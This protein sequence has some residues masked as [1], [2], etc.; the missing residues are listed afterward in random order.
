M[1]IP[2]LIFS[3][4]LD[5]ARVRDHH[6]L[7]LFLYIFY[8]GTNPIDKVTQYAD[9]MFDLLKRCI[10]LAEVWVHKESYFPLKASRRR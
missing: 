8:P 2:P 6:D 7:T 3:S 10:C 1:L 4:L 9:G 5:C